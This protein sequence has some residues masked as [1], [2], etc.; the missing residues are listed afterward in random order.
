MNSALFIIMT[1]MWF[2]KQIPCVICRQ[3]RE[4]KKKYFF[5]SFS[6]KPV[7]VRAQLVLQSLHIMNYFSTEFCRH[8]IKVSQ[9]NLE[10]VKRS[11]M[12][13]SILNQG[14]YEK[15]AMH[16]LVVIRSGSYIIPNNL[17]SKAEVK[18]YFLVGWM[19]YIIQVRVYSQT[20][21]SFG[22]KSKHFLTHVILNWKVI[23]RK[24]EEK[25]F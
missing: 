18:S 1:V 8:I 10:I 19:N 3:K 23:R 5:P 14:W 12:R 9:M 15:R 2:L 6:C 7:L 11:Q 4:Q 25:H 22:K 13:N 24:N 20:T 16:S 17:L 21:L